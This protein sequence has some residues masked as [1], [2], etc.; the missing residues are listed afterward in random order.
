MGNARFQ[1]L[2][3]TIKA[4]IP[5]V[6]PGSAASGPILQFLVAELLA[7]EYAKMNPT[8]IAPGEFFTR[9]YNG[10]K[11]N[12]GLLASV[13]NYNY[14]FKHVYPFA[15]QPLSLSQ[16]SAELFAF[17]KEYEIPVTLTGASIN[18]TQSKIGRASCR[19]RV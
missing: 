10:I 2:N 1:Q 6:I 11:S 15:T 13:S 3:D 8:G 4:A 14:P 9:V 16:A 7:T 12:P 19:E 17:F 18:S 5:G